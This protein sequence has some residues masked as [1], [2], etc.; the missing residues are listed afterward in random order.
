MHEIEQLLD[1]V[2]TAWSRAVGCQ[3][4]VVSGTHLG[5]YPGLPATGRH[6]S[7]RIV[8]V[9]QIE[10]GRVQRYSDYWDFATMAAQLG[11][12]LSVPNA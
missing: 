8:S 5:D 6:F 7:V 10:G 2:R 3:E 9:A 4:G 12:P 1:D 11:L